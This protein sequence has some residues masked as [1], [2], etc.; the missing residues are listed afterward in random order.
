MTWDL[1][2][3][4]KDDAAFDVAYNQLTEELNQAE[5]FKGTLGNGA[6]AFLAAL[7]YVLD[8]YRKVETLYVYSHLKNDQDTTNTAYQAL[9]ARASS[10]YAQVS[11]AVSWFDPEVLTLSDEQIWGYFE[12]QPK[13]AVYRHYIQNILDERPHVLS[14]EQEALLA[15]ASEIFGASSNTFS[16]LN[17]ADLEFPTVQNAE[18][19]TIQLSHGVYGQL[20]ESVDPSV[21]EAAFKGL[22]K[23]YKHFRCTC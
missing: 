7:E 15:G 12:E 5:S 2:K 19:E 6:E 21:R 9:Y 14:M 13:L 10:L 22:Y 17:N 3:I 23:V 4:F 8:V 16:I 1:T 11:E 18:G 20:M